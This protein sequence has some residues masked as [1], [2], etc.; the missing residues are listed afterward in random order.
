MKLLEN[1]VVIVTGSRRGIGHGI[2]ESMLDAG[3]CVMGCAMGEDTANEVPQHTEKL[4]IKNKYYYKKC[5]VADA[6][7]LAEFIH[8]TAHALGRIDCLVNNAGVH[9]PTQSIDDFSVGDFRQLLEINLLSMF[10]ACKEALP[11]L[12]TSK[13]SI[14]NMGSLVGAMGQEGATIYC[15]TK[16]AISAFTKAL[17]IDEGRNGVRVNAILPGTI[18]TP[19][20]DVW[21]QA[22]P[23][24]QAKLR[25]IDSWNWLN[26]QGTLKECGDSAVFLASSMSSYITGHEL[27]LSGGAELGYGIKMGDVGPQHSL[28]QH[29]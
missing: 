27:V 9:P 23:D 25:E 24:P 4:E 8:W 19:S 12:R 6:G 10:V 15:A 14:I 1:R 5:N 17:A 22:F 3:A 13:G 11:Y 18:Y 26:R 7:A 2:V 28:K 20:A 21:A 29:D 16:G